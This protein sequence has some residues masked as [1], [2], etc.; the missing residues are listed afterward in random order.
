MLSLKGSSAAIPQHRFKI[1]SLILTTAK[2]S[3]GTVL[4]QEPGKTCALGQSQQLLAVIFISPI[5]SRPAL[6][7][8]T[9]AVQVRTSALQ[10]GARVLPGW[11]RAA[12]ISGD[13]WPSY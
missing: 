2:L 12:E 1:A 7:A 13:Y 10:I 5:P 9:T 11:L 3:S 6:A 4:Y 8:V